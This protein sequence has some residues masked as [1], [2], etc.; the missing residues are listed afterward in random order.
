MRGSKLLLD[1]MGPALHD[2]FLAVRSAEA[3][4]FRRSP[5]EKIISAYRW[6]F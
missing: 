6:R 5:D 1:T 4:Q 2:A 3:D